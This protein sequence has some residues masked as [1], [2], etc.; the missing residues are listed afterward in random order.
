MSTTLTIFSV[1]VSAALVCLVV[2]GLQKTQ[3]IVSPVNQIH[4]HSSCP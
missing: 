2:G 4:V 1:T 3:Q